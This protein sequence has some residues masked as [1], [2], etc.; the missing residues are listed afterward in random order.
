[1]SP[2]AFLGF[3][4]VTLVVIIAA[5]F[6]IVSRYEVDTSGSSEARLLLRAVPAQAKAGHHDD[7]REYE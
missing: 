2:K 6:S 1:M 5:A 4:I 3:S 7:R